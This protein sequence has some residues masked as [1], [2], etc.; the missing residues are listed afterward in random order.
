MNKFILPH[1]VE[2]VIERLAECGFEAYAVGGCVRNFMLGIE[3][4]DYDVTT[5]AK[6]DEMK[7]ALNDFR[8]VETGIRYGT[9]TVI[10]GGM[11]I[12]VTTYRVDGN[13]TD[14][15]RPD[16]VI[17]TTK[18]AEDLRRRD[19]TVN[20]MAYSS[21]TGIIDIFGGRADLQSGIIRAIGDP[22]ERFGEDGLRILRALRFASCYGLKIEPKT[23]EAVHRNRL[24][25]D[26]IAGERIATEFNRLMCGDCENVL[27][28]YCDVVSVFLPELAK[29]KGF[30]QHTKYHDRDVLE[31]ILA[32][33]GAIEPK[34]H[35]RLT[36]LLHDIGKPLYFTMG[37]DGVGHFKG[38]AKG[39][40]AIAE[41]FF[42]R[43]KYSNAVSERVTQLVQTHDI[44]IENR[45]T[46]IKRYLNRYG[47]EVFFDMIK[48][49]IADDMGKAPECRERIKTYRAAAE[50]ARRII[51]QKECFSLKQLAVNGSDIKAL[52]YEGAEIG[53]KLR[54]LLELVIDGK[55]ENEKNALISAVT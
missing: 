13:Y 27:R 38:H 25:L 18:L 31:H 21:R 51:A 5:S 44:P 40:T 50:T 23:A 14:N 33:V 48:V 49:H 12:E 30:E 19:F 9:L 46:L 28:E 10:S 15:R 4:K 8:I 53:E 34:L 47:E 22:D 52:G 2:A 11:P 29:C 37:E 7:Q 3:P 43:L 45:E 16:N 6:P 55:C 20:A 1:G 39:S 26:N 24:L 54:E 42:K 36:M 17:F 32:T 41:S 35:L